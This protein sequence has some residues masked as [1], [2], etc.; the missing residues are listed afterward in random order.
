MNKLLIGATTAALFTVPAA[1][2][3]IAVTVGGYMNSM[4]YSV[5]STPYRYDHSLKMDY[6]QR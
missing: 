1:A 4:Y 6:Q 2:G 3:P 5:M